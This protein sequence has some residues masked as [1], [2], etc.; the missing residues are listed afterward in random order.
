M[1]QSEIDIMFTTGVGIRIQ[2]SRGILN[3]MITIPEN[4]KEVSV[5][6]SI[7]VILQKY[8]FIFFLAL[9]FNIQ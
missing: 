8:Y 6:S 9:Y 2:E 3:L 7:F 1:N 4:Y 5:V